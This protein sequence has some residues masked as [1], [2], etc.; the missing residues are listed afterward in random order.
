[1]KNTQNGQLSRIEGLEGIYLHKLLI[2]ST[3]F[4]KLKI[5]LAFTKSIKII[6]FFFFVFIPLSNMLY[7]IKI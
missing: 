3:I 5:E 7:F 1:M 2:E 4:Q 6:T